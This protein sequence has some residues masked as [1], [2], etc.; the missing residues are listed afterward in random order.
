MNHSIT[1]PSIVLIS[2]AKK[3][4]EEATVWFPFILEICDSLFL[5]VENTE[6]QAVP[7][8]QSVMLRYCL[9]LLDQLAWQMRREENL[10]SLLSS[11]L[12]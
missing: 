8:K 11:S 5:V 2:A 9:R 10:Q 4:A 1:L 6:S 7:R 3:R 12:L